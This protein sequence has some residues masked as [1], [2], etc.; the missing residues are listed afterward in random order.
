MR[1]LSIVES[2]TLAQ[3]GVCADDGS[4]WWAHQFVKGC[5]EGSH[6]AWKPALEKLAPASALPFLLPANQQVI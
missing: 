2:T 4:A 3:D 1:L 5:V 6:Q